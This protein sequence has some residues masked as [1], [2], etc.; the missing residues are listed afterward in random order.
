MGNWQNDT[1]KDKHNTRRKSCPGRCLEHVSHVDEPIYMNGLVG[2][3][4]YIRIQCW[5]DGNIT[6]ANLL[7]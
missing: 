3:L 1:E 4:L 5:I 2:R 6:T 7:L